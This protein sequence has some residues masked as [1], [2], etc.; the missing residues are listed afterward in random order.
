MRS[1]ETE[2]AFP[3]YHKTSS[4]RSLSSDGSTTVTDDASSFWSSFFVEEKT[5]EET[6]GF[7][8]VAFMVEA[9][10]GCGKEPGSFVE[11][12]SFVAASFVGIAGEPLSAAASLLCLSME[13]KNKPGNCLKPASS[14]VFLMN[15]DRR[16]T[17]TAMRNSLPA[18]SFAAP[19]ISKS[20]C[21]FLTAKREAPAAF[22]SASSSAGFGVTV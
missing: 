18:S 16:S 20:R 14:A 21:A 13:T 15:C 17:R 19:M 2:A 11:V 1:D 3:A 22:S 6:L 9:S 4:S 8:S 5:S 7:T 10:T 12:S